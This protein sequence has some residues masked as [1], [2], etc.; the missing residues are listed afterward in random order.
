M[1]KNSTMG[2]LT[3][4]EG[5]ADELDPAAGHADMPKPKPLAVLDRVSGDAPHHPRLDGLG[6]PDGSLK[7]LK[8]TSFGQCCIRGG[9]K[10]S[11]RVV[12][13]DHVHRVGA[14]PRAG[15]HHGRDIQLVLEVG[16][17]DGEADGSLE[18]SRVDISWNPASE[19]TADHSCGLP[20][21]GVGATLL[22]TL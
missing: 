4:H 21:I 12:V 22:G 3:R 13:E 8:K 19:K 11:D 9:F 2:P 15:P 18:F 6:A 7:T 16:H 20:S 5:K 17:P 1:S 10:L 14:T